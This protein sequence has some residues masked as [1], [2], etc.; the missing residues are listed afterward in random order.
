MIQWRAQWLKWMQILGLGLFAA[1]IFPV[2]AHPEG[3]PPGHT[4]MHGEPDCGQCHFAGAEPTKRSGLF[5]T[6]YPTQATPGAV[7]ELK[8]LLIDSE[9]RAG[10]FQLAVVSPASEAQEELTSVG[11]LAAGNLQR[12]DS[13]ARVSYVGH[14]APKPSQ[15]DADTGDMYTQ[16]MVRWRA[17]ENHSGPVQ[18]I[19]AAVAS[20]HDD[21]PLGDTVYLYQSEL[22]NAVQKP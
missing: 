2:Y 22:F 7:Y 17:P 5:V 13:L 18:I 21:S 4:G 12:V 3:P 16:W 14:S 6:G 9:H 20:D 10:G 1:V 11:E 15:E 19:A 8:V